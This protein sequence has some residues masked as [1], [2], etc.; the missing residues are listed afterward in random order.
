MLLR[1]N[2]LYWQILFNPLKKNI[3]IRFWNE[4]ILL[5]HH[6]TY[7]DMIL[8][9]AFELFFLGFSFY[10]RLHF[11]K[12]N[13]TKVPFKNIHILQKHDIK[14]RKKHENE[15]FFSNFSPKKY[16]KVHFVYCDVENEL[17]KLS[18]L[19]IKFSS[20]R[21]LCLKE[22]A[23][24]KLGWQDSCSGRQSCDT[25]RIQKSTCIPNFD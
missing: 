5:F 2:S 23:N 1:N 22:K 8:V 16:L 14:G 4:K 7:S 21:A 20:I 9:G 13:F 18:N 6:F 11:W 3:S 25:W 10:W 19:T 17:R 15:L 24:L 12:K